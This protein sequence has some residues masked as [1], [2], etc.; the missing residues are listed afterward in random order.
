MKNVLTA[1]RL[2]DRTTPTI[3]T[4]NSVLDTVALDGVVTLREAI[5][6][7]NNNAP[8]GDAPAGS[9]V[10][11]DEIHFNLPAGSGPIVI[12][13]TQLPAITEAVSILGDTQPGYTGDPLV[14]VASQG[15]YDTT[16]PRVPVGF[17]LIGHTGSTI[18]GLYIVGFGQNQI[19][20]D[21]SAVSIATSGQHTL[22]SN[23]IAGYV[24][25][26]PSF[27]LSTG[28]DI[29]GDGRNYV[30]DNR[31]D[32]CI[33]HY[34][35]IASNDNV[36]QR[37][38]FGW[39]DADIHPAS[40]GVYLAA[41]SLSPT[42]LASG[43]TIGG[44]DNSG[45]ASQGNSFSRCLIG[46][47]AEYPQYTNALLGNT[48]RGSGSDNGIG[49]GRKELGPDPTPPNVGR[50]PVLSSATSDAGSTSV[51]GTLQ[52]RPNFRYRLEFFQAPD[53]RQVANQGR[54]FLGYFDVI[55][56]ST[57]TASFTTNQRLLPTRGNITATATERDVV[58][59]ITTA[60][61]EFAANV[62]VR[63][64]RYLA[65]GTD[66]GTPSQAK[67]FR[68]DG[69]VALSVQPYG[70]FTAGVRV[71]SG[72]VNGD[73]VDDLITAAGP[74]GGPH[75]KVFSGVDG[76][77]LTSFFAYVPGF[78][79]GVFIAAGDFDGDGLSEI[80]TG[81]DAGGG[82]HVQTFNGRTGERGNGFFAYDQGF[83]GGIRVATGDYDSDGRDEIITG[84]GAG[85]GPH[86]KVFDTFGNAVSSF[87]AYDPS[88]SKGIYVTAGDLDGDGRSE[89]ITGAGAGGGPHVKVF[90][91]RTGQ[92][93]PGGF[94]AYPT[95]FS[96]GVR[97]AMFDVDQ[98]GK[99]NLAFGAGPGGG[100]HVV[101]FAA[102][103]GNLGSFFPFDQSL[104]SGVFVGA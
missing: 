95:N 38:K 42:L 88:F 5:F 76:S 3:I 14:S 49:I 18:K 33:N 58:N 36:F 7:A 54:K 72:D 73:N 40:S 64:A 27:V 61:S 13:G 8:I 21:R 84:A 101:V 24:L 68:A 26:Y 86:V 70:G 52:G 2:E 71:A 39:Y 45:G 103:A 32:L 25:G 102:N 53:G 83:S 80:V 92:E 89:I 20:I 12:T 10:Q 63:P 35:R 104:T 85:G 15:T 99:D 30:Y 67:L 41:N 82:P 96:G 78:N 46:I 9:S 74:G 43:N 16:T 22:A 37:N 29:R 57:G 1:T 4:V 77:L 66:A 60:T 100:P 90:D 69:T 48:F 6:A 93:K 65:V 97:V 34:V 56:D 81:A 23:W 59:K 51:I 44:I 50:A 87:F 79:K 75:V 62:P 28:I 55:T 94:F 11:T 91:I 17:R 19:V 98:D 31:I 47:R